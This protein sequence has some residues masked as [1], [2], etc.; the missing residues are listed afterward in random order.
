[1]FIKLNN[2]HF[3]KYKT[4]S[5]LKDFQIGYSRLKKAVK[6]YREIKKNLSKPI[7]TISFDLKENEDLVI[8][9]EDKTSLKVFC[10]NL[11]KEKFLINKIN[12]DIITI[13]NPVKSFIFD[14]FNFKYIKYLL[15]NF[16]I[17]EINQKK[18]KDNLIY[19]KNNIEDKNI[20]EFIIFNDLINI[21]K[22]IIIFYDY[23]PFNVYQKEEYMKIKSHNII[24]HLVSSEKN[25]RNLEK[26]IGEFKF[27]FNINS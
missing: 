13:Y 2:Y 3:Y 1:M 10:D 24:I 18:I 9:F 27:K 15:Y 22:K 11:K 26:Y 6:N 4:F 23:F 20:Q 7:K 25:F 14:S 16:N 17:K 19:Y 21:K 8:Y 5:K 12:F